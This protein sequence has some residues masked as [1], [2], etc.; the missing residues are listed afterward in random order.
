MKRSA[1]TA[2]AAIGLLAATVSATGTAHAQQAQPEVQH[3]TIYVMA[4]EMGLVGPD[5]LH[6]DSFIPSSFVVKAGEPVQLTIINYD[7][8]GTHS[9]RPIS[10]SISWSS[11]ARTLPAATR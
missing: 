1:M 7:T 8:R 5:K 9:A 6:H 3:V 2:L 11:R 4:D 10:A